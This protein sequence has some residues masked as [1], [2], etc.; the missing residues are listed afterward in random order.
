MELALAEARDTTHTNDVPVGA[1]VVDAQ[2]NVIGRGRNRRE[3][4]GDPTAHAEFQ[5][6]AAEQSALAKAIT[7]QIRALRAA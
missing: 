7:S 2:G 4:S 5:R 6:L 3:E 1:I